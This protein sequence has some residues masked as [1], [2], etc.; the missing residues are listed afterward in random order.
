MTRMDIPMI[1]LSWTL[2]V[3]VEDKDSQLTVTETTYTRGTD[4]NKTAAV[5][6]NSDQQ[7]QILHRLHRKFRRK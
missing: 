5:F 1:Q 3:K 6:T 7:Q 4:S 2:T